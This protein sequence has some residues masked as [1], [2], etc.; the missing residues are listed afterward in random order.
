[1]GKYFALEVEFENYFFVSLRWKSFSWK[2]R[3]L[4]E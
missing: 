1:M 4:L 3:L 2:I